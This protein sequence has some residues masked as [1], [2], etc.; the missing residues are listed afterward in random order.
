MKNNTPENSNDEDDI[1]KDMKELPD[2]YNKICLFLIKNGFCTIEYIKLILE[3][4]TLEEA[5]EKLNKRFIWLKTHSIIW[6]PLYFP[7]DGEL[8]KQLQFQNASAGLWNVHDFKDTF[9]SKNKLTHTDLSTELA[10][11]PI[12]K[13][14]VNQNSNKNIET[15]IWVFNFFQLEDI[16]KFSKLNISKALEYWALEEVTYIEAYEKIGNQDWI[17]DID[18]LNITDKKV[19]QVTPK[20]NTLIIPMAKWWDKT[21]P[22]SEWK[23]WKSWIITPSFS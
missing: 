12:E 22:L 17:D 9:I 5:K 16:I 3:W 4:D 2:W 20:W 7:D 18:I 1:F 14:L 10:F 6:N 21:P 11:F 23:K 13:K 15:P 19:F 8:K